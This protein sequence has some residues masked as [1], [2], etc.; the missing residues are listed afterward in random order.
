MQLLETME[1]TDEAVQTWN[2]LLTL[3]DSGDALSSMQGVPEGC[4]LFGKRVDDGSA[5]QPQDVRPW[6]THSGVDEQCERPLRLAL[7]SNWRMAGLSG[8]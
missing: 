7:G 1:R 6:R 2:A 3:I 4:P 5:A 8:S